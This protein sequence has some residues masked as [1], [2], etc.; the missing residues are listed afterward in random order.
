MENFSDD[1][2]LAPNETKTFQ[3]EFNSSSPKKEFV[4]LRPILKYSL[5]SDD[6]LYSLPLPTSIY[7]PPISETEITALFEEGKVNN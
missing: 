2:C 6:I 7:S 3:F 1:L 5:G 4:S